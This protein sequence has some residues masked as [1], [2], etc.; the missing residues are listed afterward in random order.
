MIA[1]F[2]ARANLPLYSQEHTDWEE[3]WDDLPVA[4]DEGLDFSVSAVPPAPQRKRVISRAEIECAAAPNLTALLEETLGLGVTA[5]GPYGNPAS[6]NMHG[7]GSGR[8]AVLLDGVPVNSPQSGTFNLESVDIDA[9]ERIEVTYG[10]G[11]AEFNVSGA[12]GGVI[13][14][15]TDKKGGKGLRFGGGVSNTSALPG[16]Y[17]KP[18]GGK[19][20]PAWEDLFDT[21]RIHGFVGNGGEVFSFQTNVFAT[22]A[23]NHFLFSTGGRADRTRRRTGNEIYDAGGSLSLNWNLPD[24]TRLRYAGDVY[25]GDKNTAGTSDS[26]AVGKMKELS[27]RHSVFMDNPTVF[28]DDLA[29]DAALSYSLQNLSYRNAVPAGFVSSSEADSR[30]RL[31]SLRIANGWDWYTSDRF[32]LTA[33]ADY[34]FAYLDSTNTGK[35]Q[36]HSGGLSLTGALIAGKLTIIPSVKAVLDAGSGS[37]LSFVPVPKLGL[38]WRLTDEFSIRNSCF[39][40]FKLPTFNDRYWAGDATARGN[41]SLRPEDG[42]GADIGASYKGAFTFDVSLHASYIQNSIHWRS[43]GNVWSPANIGEAAFAGADLFLLFTILKKKNPATDGVELHLSFSYNY[44]L[45]Y[46]LTENLTF[47]SNKRMPYMPEHAFTTALDLRWKSGSAL[48]GGAFTG[49]RYTET[50]NIA[51]AKLKPYFLLNLTINQSLSDTF[52]VFAVFRNLLNVSYE[53]VKDY[54]MRGFTLTLGLRAEFGSNAP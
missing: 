43:A 33:D 52:T 27:T 20:A 22:R 10:G 53:S 21:Q 37:R 5:N 54:P 23:A 51:S 34:G 36:G 14:I 50:L 29:V 38:V 9:V 25:Y 17:Q 30:H 13:N 3:E 4:E 16:A 1:A 42:W 11:S 31:H 7:M 28:R 46:I 40:A 12:M 6:V 26:T 48:L 18:D 19:G 2:S 15:V 24:L 44:L 35:K 39:R 41:P 49:S 45:S 32:T 47:A 8:V